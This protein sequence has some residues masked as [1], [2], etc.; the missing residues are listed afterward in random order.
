MPLSTYVGWDGNEQQCETSV[1]TLIL[2]LIWT[3]DCSKSI[4]CKL[5]ISQWRVLVGHSSVTPWLLFCIEISYLMC[6]TKV[7]GRADQFYN[8]LFYI[9]KH[10]CI[11]SADSAHI[12]VFCIFVFANIYICIFVPILVPALL[13]LLISLLLCI[14]VFGKIY[15][16]LY[17][18]FDQQHFLPAHICCRFPPWPAPYPTVTHLGQPQI[19]HCIINAWPSLANFSSLFENGG[20]LVWRHQCNAWSSLSCFSSLFD[21]ATLHLFCKCFWGWRRESL[22][23]RCIITSLRSVAHFRREHFSGNAKRMPGSYQKQILVNFDVDIF[24]I[25]DIAFYYYFSFR[26]YYFTHIFGVRVSLR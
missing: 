17:V 16:S 3:L 8:D 11:Y 15:V 21:T 24:F 4:R 19:R 25:Y 13:Y 9:C 10:L 23:F 14:F 12:L 20:N 18:H 7:T 5:C 6:S 1:F 2:I 26:T 22:C